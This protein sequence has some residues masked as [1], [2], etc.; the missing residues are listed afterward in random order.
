MAGLYRSKGCVL[1]RTQQTER[2]SRV[3]PGDREHQSRQ[4]CLAP[5][6]STP[7]AASV[8]QAVNAPCMQRKAV[9]EAASEA[10][11]QRPEKTHRGSL[12]FH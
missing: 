1:R 5:R 6:C 11:R 12:Q 8:L 9:V 2:R 10:A 7:G 4:R 3:D